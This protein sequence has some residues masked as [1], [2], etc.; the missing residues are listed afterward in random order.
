MGS[1]GEV[2]WS[3]VGLGLVVSS[4]SFMETYES[5]CAILEIGWEAMWVEELDLR[6]GDFLGRKY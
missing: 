3:G 2:L 6:F 4:F 1:L 5:I